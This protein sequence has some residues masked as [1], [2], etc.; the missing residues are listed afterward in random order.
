[1]MRFLRGK[2]LRQPFIKTQLLL[3]S[4][5]AVEIP[6]SSEA[7]AVSETN[8][9]ACRHYLTFNLHVLSP[10]GSSNEMLHCEEHRNKELQR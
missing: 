2:L 10:S 1:M 7:P 8:G 9:A 5:S 3:R 6:N 4:L